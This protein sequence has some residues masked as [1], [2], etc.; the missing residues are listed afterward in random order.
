MV[1]PYIANAGAVINK[2][3]A[4]LGLISGLAPLE[5]SRPRRLPMRLFTPLGTMS[6]TGRVGLLTGLVGYWPR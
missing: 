4:S 3:P 2:A 6:L 1:F 5:V